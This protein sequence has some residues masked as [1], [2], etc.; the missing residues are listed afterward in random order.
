MKRRTYKA[1]HYAFSSIPPL[2]ST[3][4]HTFPQHPLF[5]HPQYTYFIMPVY[6]ENNNSGVENCVA[7]HLC[8]YFK[9]VLNLHMGLTELTPSNK[10]FRDSEARS[11]HARNVARPLVT[12]RLPIIFTHTSNAVRR[13]NSGLRKVF[14]NVLKTDD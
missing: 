12:R 14:S 8:P 13:E 6:L 5:R 11:T 7:H 3:S 4:V 9:W 10:V 1:P 2:T